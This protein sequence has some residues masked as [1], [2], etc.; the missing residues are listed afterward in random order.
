MAVGEGTSN[1]VFFLLQLCLS[2]FY[3]PNFI[4][5]TIKHTH[6]N[7]AKKVEDNA[8]NKSTRIFR[9]TIVGSFFAQYC[10]AEW[11]QLSFGVAI[12]G[13]CHD[14]IFKFSKQLKNIKKTDE[15]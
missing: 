15:F 9:I 11:I 8:R 14:M 7:S 1:L 5:N 12:D 2:N 13:T 10:S 6:N 3:N 4:K